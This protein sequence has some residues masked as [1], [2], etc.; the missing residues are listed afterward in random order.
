[1][2][3]VNH[4]PVRVVRIGLLSDL[5]VRAC[6][7]LCDAVPSTAS[8]H[9]HWPREEMKGGVRGVQTITCFGPCRVTII[10]HTSLVFAYASRAGTSRNDQC[11]FPASVFKERKVGKEVH[12]K[13]DVWLQNLTHRVRLCCGKRADSPAKV[14]SLTMEQLS[15]WLLS[16]IAVRLISAERSPRNEIGP[17]WEVVSVYD[18]HNCRSLHLRASKSKGSSS[19]GG[20]GAKPGRTKRLHRAT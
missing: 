7:S 3:N 20:G 13:C 2:R 19:S 4:G 16:S 18:H 9:F 11:S 6:V 17:R 5:V 15:G 8:S 14:R 12:S 1:M 10:A